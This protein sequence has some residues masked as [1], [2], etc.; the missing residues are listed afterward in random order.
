MIVCV[1]VEHLFGHGEDVELLA[2]EGFDL[3]FSESACYR[4]Q[5]LGSVGGFELYGVKKCSVLVGQFF[6]WVF[7]YN[8]NQY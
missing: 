8:R 3:I 5:G 1:L 6:E 2:G 4:S 7:H